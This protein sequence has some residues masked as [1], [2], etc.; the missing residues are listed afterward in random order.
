[1]S[2][3]R[4]QSPFHSPVTRVLSEG[5]TDSTGNKIDITRGFLVCSYMPIIIADTPV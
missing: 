1:M 5:V 2:Q 4:D 3:V